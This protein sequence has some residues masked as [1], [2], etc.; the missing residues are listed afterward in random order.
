MRTFITY[1]D[2]KRFAKEVDSQSLL[3]EAS[4]REG[5]TVFLSHSSD[6]H[7]LL[8]GVIRVLEGHGARVYVDDKDPLLPKP[9]FTETANRLRSAVRACE[10]FVLFVTPRTKGSTWIPWEMGLGDGRHGEARVALFPSAENQY[11]HQCAEEEFLGL[12][13]RIIWGNFTDKKPEWLVLNHRTNT[14]LPLRQW[15]TESRKS[16]RTTA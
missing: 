3:K 9:D 13:K 14:A 1:E 10:R 6:D 7:D 2:L 12:Y 16:R 15:L 5:K 4:R 11:V 8:P